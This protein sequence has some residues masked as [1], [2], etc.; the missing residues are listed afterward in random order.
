MH[1]LYPAEYKAKCSASDFAEIMTFSWAYLGVPEDV[2]V[3]VENLRIDGNL[4]WA[5]IRF[6]KE[7]VEIVIGEESTENDP[8]FTWEDGQWVIYVSPEYLAEDDPC[9]LDF[10]N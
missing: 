10:G 7:G 3:I 4:A 2:T 5:E 9:R 1:G 8:T 6:E